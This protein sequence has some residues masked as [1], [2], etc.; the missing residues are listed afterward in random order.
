MENNLEQNEFTVWEKVFDYLVM[1]C[2][3][4]MFSKTLMHEYLDKLNVYKNKLMEKGLI[5]YSE[6]KILFIWTGKNKW[7]LTPKWNKKYSNDLSRARISLHKNPILLD[8]FKRNNYDRIFDM[9][10]NDINNI[11]MLF[12]KSGKFKRE[13]FVGYT[14]LF[15]EKT[16]LIYVMNE[17]WKEMI[18]T[19]IFWSKYHEKIRNLIN[20]ME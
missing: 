20:E 6:W 19:L 9:S 17:L 10:D 2:I 4:C 3:K 7:K 5:E 11:I 15:I 13:D 8:C 1:D 16:E 14:E 12:L 18:I